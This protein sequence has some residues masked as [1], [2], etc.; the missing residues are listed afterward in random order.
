MTTLMEVQEQDV[1]TAVQ[2]D[3]GKPVSL[4]PLPP[5]FAAAL[6]E[7]DDTERRRRKW[8]A[9]SSIAFQS[10]LLGVVL[11]V[12]LMFTDVLPAHELLTMLV[13]PPPPPPPPPPAAAVQAVRRIQ[14]DMM[15]GRL[16]TPSR[17]PQK[18]EMIR[19]EE[20][21]PQSAGV[22]GGVP[23]GMPGGQLG[24]VIGGIISSNSNIS[25]VPKLAA[26]RRIRISQGVTTGLLVHKVEPEYPAIA[27]AAHIQGQVIL[28]AVISKTGVIEN[29]TTVS[30][31]PTLVPAAI[32]AVKHWQ[33]RPYLLNGEP[34]EV[35]TTITVSFAFSS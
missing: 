6:L 16:K 35:E 7:P 23:G 8:A 12:P 18:V 31:H 15:D 19:E 32:E 2:P 1:R 33:Y 25:I 30:G 3:V 24:G 34:V 11:I 27:K 9:V 17:I 29:I 28:N 10:L 5:L 13:A 20:A 21:P 26:P 22:I 14:S 4:P